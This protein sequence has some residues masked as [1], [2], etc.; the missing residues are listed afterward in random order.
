M[1]SDRKG[2]AIVIMGVSGSGKSTVAAL[3]AKNLGCGFL[4][5]DDFHPQSNK[6]K[7]GKGIPLTDEDRTP[8]LESLKNATREKI[9]NGETVVLT[10]SA[11]QKR[12]RDVLRASDP[13]YEAGNYDCRVKFVC[14]TASKEV[15]FARVERRAKEG[16]HFMPPELLQSQLDLLQVDKSER[17]IMVDA[18]DSPDSVVYIIQAQ[19]IQNKAEVN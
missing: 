18:T 17:V 11:L 12:Y 13:D 7:M 19:I 16:K 1:A 10:C 8:W 14:L 15:I 5:A 4:E 6:E 3:L 2:L 9:L